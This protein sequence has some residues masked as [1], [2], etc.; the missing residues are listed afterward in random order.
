MNHIKEEAWNPTYSWTSPLAVWCAALSVNKPSTWNQ[1]TNKVLLD[2]EDP[3]CTQSYFLL[4]NSVPMDEL[5]CILNTWKHTLHAPRVPVKWDTNPLRRPWTRQ[6]TLGFT[7]FMNTPLTK[8]SSRSSLVTFLAS[9]NFKLGSLCR[10]KHLEENR[11]RQLRRVGDHLKVP[12]NVSGIWQ[13]SS[14]DILT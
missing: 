14:T 5:S 1:P 12:C 10:T 7:T 11:Q 2:W 8:A 4:G 6:L 3:V 9:K 13:F